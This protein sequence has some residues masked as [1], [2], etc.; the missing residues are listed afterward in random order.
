MRLEYLCLLTTTNFEAFSVY[1]LHLHLF[2]PLPFSETRK[3]SEIGNILQFFLPYQLTLK[4][5]LSIPASSTTPFL[6]RPH[7]AA[8]ADDRLVHVSVRCEEGCYERVYFGFALYIIHG[9][10]VVV[11]VLRGFGFRLA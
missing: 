10:R 2:L 11:G 5:R 4:P 6:S 3:L 9:A 7:I 8:A 1:I